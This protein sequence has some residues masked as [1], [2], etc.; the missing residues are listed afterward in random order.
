MGAQEDAD[1]SYV[2]RL[3]NYQVPQ[4]AVDRVALAWPV[5]HGYNPSAPCNVHDVSF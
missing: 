2:S 4:E 1:L 5:V 3:V